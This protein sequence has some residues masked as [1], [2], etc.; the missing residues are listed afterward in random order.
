MSRLRRPFLYDRYTFVTV[1]LLRSRDELEQRDYAW[2]SICRARMRQK[3][4][5]TLSTFASVGF[6][7]LREPTVKSS[8]DLNRG[9]QNVATSATDAS[10]QARTPPGVFSIGMR[11]PA[12]T[13][14]SRPA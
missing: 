9:Y 2:S 1:D 11:H 5:A 8:Y 12:V 10:R 13:C 14:I 7:R 6:F 3:Q 4:V